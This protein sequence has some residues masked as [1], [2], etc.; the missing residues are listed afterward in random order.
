MVFKH[1]RVYDTYFIHTNCNE[2]HNQTC[3]MYIQQLEST[4]G[5]DDR[6]VEYSLLL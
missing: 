4:L 6:Q 5:Q 2:L 1:A 3:R